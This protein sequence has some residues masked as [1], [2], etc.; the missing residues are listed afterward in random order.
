M[1]I[2]DLTPEILRLFIQR[3]EVG[4]RSGKA[5]RNAI[6]VKIGSYRLALKPPKS[7]L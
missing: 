3:I 2:G 5:S 7:T 4:D 1:R 6:A